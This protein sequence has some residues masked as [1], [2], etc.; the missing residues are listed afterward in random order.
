VE[1]GKVP[2][3]ALE[4]FTPTVYLYDNYPGGVVT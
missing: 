1:G 4:Q 3:A 2:L